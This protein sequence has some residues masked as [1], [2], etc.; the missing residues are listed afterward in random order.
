M[1]SK[2][3]ISDSQT[4]VQEQ[5]PNGSD[6]DAVNT[7]AAE[8]AA[9][10]AAAFDPAEF[11]PSDFEQAQESA[12][13]K[14]P[15]AFAVTAFSMIKGALFPAKPSAERAEKAPAMTGTIQ[16]D[17][18]TLRV[19]FAAFLK[20]GRESGLLYCDLSIGFKNGPR[21]YGRLFPATHKNHP[22]A[23]DY[24][25]YIVLLPVTHK[26]QY[27]MQDWED[28]PTL[29]IRGY[30]RRNAADNRARIQLL[31]APVKVGDHE[32]PL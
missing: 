23:P 8:A 5:N 26:G 31:G 10:D 18:S 6:F 15:P 17:D 4:L 29:P 20:S 1:A 22:S 24:S 3:R 32:L 30:R 14:V 12:P 19:P 9:A 27:T 25:G 16:I 2:K 21:L 13:A 28:A 7:A 11:Q